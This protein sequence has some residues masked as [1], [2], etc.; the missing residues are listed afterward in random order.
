MKAKKQSFK[1]TKPKALDE[2]VSSRVQESMAL[3]IEEIGAFEAKTHLSAIL[4]KVAQGASFYITK[5]GKRIAEI[6]PIEQPKKQRILGLWR[7]RIWI[8]PDFDEPLEEFK[9][10]ME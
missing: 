6:K 9:E 10:Y 1:S 3:S 5:R 8:A 2:A 4:E 7:D